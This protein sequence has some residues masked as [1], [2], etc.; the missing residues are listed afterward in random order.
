MCLDFILSHFGF[1][2]PFSLW[3]SSVIRSSGCG[4]TLRNQ[5]PQTVCLSCSVTKTKDSKLRRAGSGNSSVSRC[6]L[7]SAGLRGGLSVCADSYF[8]IRFTL[9]LLAKYWARK[10]PGPRSFCQKCRWQGTA[11]LNIRVHLIL[12]R[13]SL[14]MKWCSMVV[15]CRP[16]QNLRRD[17]ST[18]FMWYQPCQ[19]CKYTT[20]VDIQ[21]RAVKSYSVTHITVESHASAVS[22]LE[23]GDWISHCSA[24]YINWS[25]QQQL[26]SAPYP[27]PP[28]PPPPPI[29]LVPVPNKPYGFCGR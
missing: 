5:W 27:L 12:R 28:P 23:S 13:M 11:W 10:R 14:C 29:P 9:V 6:G 18:S 7:A 3:S 20:S 4:P 25:D 16:I 2:Q 24:G 21:K 15:W 17:G 22:L 1:S 19:R 8:C 26:L